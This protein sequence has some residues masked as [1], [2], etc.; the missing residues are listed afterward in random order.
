MAVL[1]WTSLA[2]VASAAADKTFM[3]TVSPD[4]LAAGGSYG[5]APRGAITLTIKN[6]SNQSQLGSANVTLP[7][8]LTVKGASSVPGTASLDPTV[9]NTIDLRNLNLQPLA[10]AV[11][12]VSAQV[13]CAAN[14]QSY[15]W[16]FVVKQANDFNGTPGNNL[17]QFGSTTSTIDGQCGLSF[18]KQPMSEEKNVTITNKIYDVGVPQSGDHPV[19]VSILDR[20]GNPVPWWSGTMSLVLGSSP[21]PATL[22]GQLT[23]ST[24]LGSVTFAPKI[25]V[26]ATGY[27]LAATAVGDVGTPSDGTSTA[28]FLSDAFTIVDD[29]TICVTAGSSCMVTASGPD[30]GH[31]VTTQAT[32]TAGA[33]GGTNGGANDLVILQVADPATDFN[34]QGYVSSTDVIAFNATTDNGL[35]PVQRVKTSQLTLFASFVTKSASQYDVCYRSSGLPFTPKG[36][37]AQVTTGILPNCAAKNPVAPCVLSR[38]ADKAKNVIVTVLSPAGDPGMK[39]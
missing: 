1:V 18:T 8:G 36:G 4:P 17:S 38:T 14:H 10:S 16:S 33:N 7:V 34:C 19:T 22:S 23:G 12:S 2:T 13:E 39:F 37:G 28:Q 31:G 26:S 5:V 30:H 6:I 29:A 32:V 21:G 11:V 20:D 35:T 27:R 15:I 3:A 9:P 24:T 25:D